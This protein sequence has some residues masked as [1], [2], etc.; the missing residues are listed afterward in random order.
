MT[1]IDN[2]SEESRERILE[3]IKDLEMISDERKDLEAA[4][5]ELREKLAAEMLEFGLDYIDNGTAEVK[6]IPPKIQQ[7]FDSK[8][9]ELDRPDLYHKYL[10]D[11]ERKGHIRISKLK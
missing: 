8:K 4:E 6:Y 3:L 1:H 10:I 9:L 11:S 5:D 2:L 7:K